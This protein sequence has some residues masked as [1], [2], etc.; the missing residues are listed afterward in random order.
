MHSKSTGRH[1]RSSQQGGLGISPVFTWMDTPLHL[2]NLGLMSMRTLHSSEALLTS[3][4]ADLLEIDPKSPDPTGGMQAL[5]ADALF[6]WAD[7]FTQAS[8]FA[9]A[10]LDTGIRWWR[11]ME[12]GVAQLLVLPSSR[13]MHITPDSAGR[14][15][16][17]PLDLSP[18]GI[19]LATAAATNALSAAWSNALEHETQVE[20][21]ES[22]AG[23]LQ[24]PPR[25]E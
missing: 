15:L 20:P 24:A 5:A 6:F 3:E 18:R 10:M 1:G 19:A 9:V 2:M 14:A 8:R 13:D 4:A 16:C 17:A 7:Q 21:A 22:S 25:S 23:A 11:D 12:A